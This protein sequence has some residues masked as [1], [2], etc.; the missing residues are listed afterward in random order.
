MAEEK[1]KEEKRFKKQV[2][3]MILDD[4]SIVEMIYD[5][6]KMKT[7]FIVFKDGE[8]TTEDLITIENMDYVPFYSIGGIVKN[9]VVLFPTGVEKFDNEDE[10]IAEVRRFIH[11]YL[12]IS[13]F[14]E[15]IATYYAMFTWIYDCFNELP[16][17]RA[18]GA[19]YPFLRTLVIQV[20]STFRNVF[21]QIPQAA[22]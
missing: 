4:G 3:S 5:P 15:S 16:Y 22:F 7:S 6:Q 19:R 20:S 17:L 11:K 9:N 2:A 13:P 12:D 21:S 18:L 8:Y 14:F 10:L 1:I